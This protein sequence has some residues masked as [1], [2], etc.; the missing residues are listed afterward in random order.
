MLKQFRVLRASTCLRYIWWINQQLF[1][2]AAA[3]LLS[4]CGGI[5]FVKFIA[6]SSSHLLRMIATHMW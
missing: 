5:K 4:Q 3:A 2:A 1:A 6:N